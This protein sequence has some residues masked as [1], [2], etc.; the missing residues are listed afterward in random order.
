MSYLKSI[1]L[2][3][4]QQLP[5]RIRLL[6]QVLQQAQLAYD[7]KLNRDVLRSAMNSASL[8]NLY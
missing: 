2:E 5:T 8:S 6:R 1:S 3:I 4:A 7:S